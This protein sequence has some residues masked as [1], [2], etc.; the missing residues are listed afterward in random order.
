MQLFS[1]YT[2]MKSLS[3]IR[4]HIDPALQ[5][6][7]SFRIEKLNSISKAR[8][9]Y[10]VPISIVIFGFVSLQLDSH[11]PYRVQFITVFCFFIAFILF[12][13]VYIFKVAP[14]RAQFIASFKHDVF[15]AFVLHLYPGSYYAPDNYLPSIIF[16]SSKLFSSFDSYKGED[17]FE[18]TTNAKT[19][20]KFSELKVSDSY[21]DSDGNQQ[22]QLVFSGLFLV[23]DIPIK[24]V[25]PI[26]VLPDTAE[27][28]TGTAG[29][30]LQR[31]FGTFFRGNQKLVY[32]NE[33][34]DFEKEF[35]VYSKDESIAKEILGPGLIE[36]LCKIKSTW[37]KKVRVS[38]I[39]NHLYVA[40]DTKHDLFHPNIKKSLLQDEVI[41]ELYEELALCFSIVEDISAGLIKKS[42]SDTD[43]KESP[44]NRRNKKNKDND[45]P[46][47]L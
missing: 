29:K 20:F 42:T 30:F 7:E 18:G 37:N 19:S 28:L 43:V 2:Q 24:V 41:N 25:N 16:K 3:D 9:W 36:A 22:N 21:S 12:F 40:I 10:L 14:H 26:F 23:L 47:L 15:S 39:D 45:N 35:V 11:F 27:K 44:I 5:Q 38:L 32:F 34:P 8:G 17:Y 33:Y 4:G 6:I 1:K 13:L 31:T 46:F